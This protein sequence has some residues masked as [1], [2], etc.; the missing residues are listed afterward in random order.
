[1]IYARIEGG[2]ITEYPVFPGDLRLRFPNVSFPVGDFDPPKGY[3]AVEE[4][5]MPDAPVGHYLL[6]G[7]PVK[8]GKQWMQS[9][10][11]TAFTEEELEQQLDMQWDMV[12]AERSLRLSQSDWTQLP[13]APLTAD[14]RDTW[15]AKRQHWR[16]VTSQPD[17][18][19]IKWL[20]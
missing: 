14:E 19:N 16:D 7:A 1:M 11:P 12:R 15:Q 4:T 5:P 2:K 20:P 13:D 6:E 17:P 9:W 8:R 10:V 18:F 3:V